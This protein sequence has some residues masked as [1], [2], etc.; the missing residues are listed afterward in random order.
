MCAMT[1]PICLM[2]SLQLFLLNTT[3]QAYVF[4]SAACYCR[5]IRP[6]LLEGVGSHSETNELFVCAKAVRVPW[7]YLFIRI[8]WISCLWPNVLPHLRIIFRERSERDLRPRDY[9]HSIT[10]FLKHGI[11]S[12]LIL[13]RGVT[14]LMGC[15]PLKKTPYSCCRAV[16]IPLTLSN[17]SSHLWPACSCNAPRVLT[18]WLISPTHW[19]RNTE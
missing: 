9:N 5:V 14:M 16:F 1:I 4:A 10:E 6:R 13:S 17:L 3:H 7:W 15:S 18:R 19:G 12:A 2:V 8:H 11:P